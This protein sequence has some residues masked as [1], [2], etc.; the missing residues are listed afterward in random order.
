MNIVLIGLRGCGKSAVGRELATRL[1]WRFVDTDALVEERTGQTIREIFADQAEA[2]FREL[3]AQVVSE[4]AHL[5]DH[6]IST[7]G[8]VVL[9][10]DNV[11]ALKGSG[12][13]VW[14]TAPPEVLWERILGDL[15][16]QQTRPALD[17][18]A[19]LQQIRDTLKHREPIYTRVADV[20]V[21]TT[22]RSVSSIVERILTRAH[23]RPPHTES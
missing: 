18:A 23:L 17:L 19:G 21:D 4:V 16:R 8:G 2:G 13:L 20:E 3:E 6:V 9:R 7:G 14:L 11:A 1:G 12:C 10:E 22:G 15:R 5:T